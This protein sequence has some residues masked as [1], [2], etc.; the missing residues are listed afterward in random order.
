MTARF[1]PWKGIDVA[2]RAA[3]PLLRARPTL[4]FLLVG[5]QYR[6][7]HPEYGPQ[8]RRLVER[9]GVASQ[10]VFAG[11]QADVRPYLARMSMLIH[12]ST[13]PEPFGLTIIEAMAVGTPVIVA[14]GGGAA[15]IIE[16][17][18]NGLAHTPGDESELRSAMIALLDDADLRLRLSTAGVR[19][20]DA[21]FRPARMMHIIEGV[22]D[23]MLAQRH[24]Q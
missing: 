16:P 10:V 9:E 14:R 7:F 24:R 18:R 13:Q 8:L 20:V 17:G 5:D 23:D 21:K 4:R 3:A 12:A 15:D 19:T 1:D 11:F 22:Y 6:H 2:L